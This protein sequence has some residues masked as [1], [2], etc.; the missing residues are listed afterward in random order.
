M[1]A[2]GED[3]ALPVDAVGR[4]QVPAVRPH[5]LSPTGPY[6]GGN[7]PTKGEGV[8]GQSFHGLAVKL[9]HPACPDVTGPSSPSLGRWE[10]G[11]RNLHNR[12]ELI[13]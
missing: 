2:T 10:V 12:C 11:G 4:Q 3:S 7:L 9:R 5:H 8:G 1:N 13:P 6:P